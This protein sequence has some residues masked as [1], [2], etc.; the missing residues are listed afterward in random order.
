MRL[1]TMCV[2]ACAVL[3]AKVPTAAAVITDPDVLMPELQQNLQ[4]IA[5]EQAKKY[6][7]GRCPVYTGREHK[8]GLSPERCEG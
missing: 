5:D 7:C 4:A 3:V 8:R 1:F 6:E 2:S